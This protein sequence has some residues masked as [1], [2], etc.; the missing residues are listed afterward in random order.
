MVC[1]EICIVNYFAKQMM[2]IEM[3]QEEIYKLYTFHGIKPKPCNRLGFYEALKF[4]LC[5]WANHHK[6]STTKSS[7]KVVL[8]QDTRGFDEISD[9][10]DQRY[11]VVHISHQY[12]LRDL[13]F[14]HDTK[15]KL[16]IGEIERKLLYIYSSHQY[17]DLSKLITKTRRQ[18][19]KMDVN[20][21]LLTNDL[22]PF[23]KV[24]T[25][26][27]REEEIPVFCIQHGTTAFFQ[28]GIDYYG[29]SSGRYIT[30]GQYFK[31]EYLKRQIMEEQ[32]IFV[33]GYPHLQFYEYERSKKDDAK[34]NDAKENNKERN[35][36]FIGSLWPVYGEGIEEAVYELVYE[37]SNLCD[38]IGATLRYRPHPLEKR[39][40]LNERFSDCGNLVISEEKNLYVDIE[41][42]DLMIGIESTVFLEA[43][44]MGKMTIQISDVMDA[45]W[46][47]AG[48]DLTYVCKLSEVTD[49]VE[50]FYRKTLQAKP[51]TG[52]C[53]YK[54]PE[55]FRD[56][57]DLIDN[58]MI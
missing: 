4:R 7:K 19:R 24:I 54:N 42:A 18:L 11:I 1:R 14:H 22:N 47:M 33:L 3:Y 31:D 8:F 13:L 44:A 51:Y 52:Y 41:T 30:W 37:L 29:R 20:T 34:E 39:E 57:C 55:F 12:G 43:N 2:E 46:D 58:A 21:V 53:L 32:N 49:M 45:N 36:L 48:L 5:E 15:L 26:A 17:Q 56:L 35:V 40:N 9:L 10:L 27:A 28:E 38:K 6:V 23:E 25:I 16:S 50:A